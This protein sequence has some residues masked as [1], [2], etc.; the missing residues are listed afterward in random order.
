MAVYYN[1]EKARHGGLTGTIISVPVQIASNDPSSSIQKAQF[2]AGYLRCD[3][4]IY[5][6]DDYP[7]LAAVLG[8]GDN[9]K[10]KKD[11][12][13][14]NATQFQLPDLRSKHIRAT[15]S[16]NIGFY[17]DLVVQTQDGDDVVK[18]GVGLEVLQNIESPYELTYNGSFYIP[19]Q[20]QA[21]KGEPAFSIDSGSYTFEREV[22]ET[23]FQPHMHRSTTSRARQVDKNGNYF[24]NSQLNSIK[25]KLSLTVCEWWKNT[26]QDLC[27]WQLT[28]AAAV[29]A[30]GKT[31]NST[32]YYEQYGLCWNACS[33][34]TTAGY[35]L[36]PST[37]ACPGLNNSKNMCIVLDVDDDCNTLK[38][39]ICE[40]TTFG[41]ITYDPT[42]TQSCVCTLQILGECPGALNGG[43]L[44]LPQNTSQLINYDDPNMPVSS[45]DDSY[46][47]GYAAV[48]NYTMLTGFKGDDAIHKHTLNFSADEPHTYVMKTR[49]GTAS[50]SAGLVSKIT[51]QKNNEPKADKYIQPYIVTEYLIKI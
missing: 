19:P 6:A 2:P 23:G 18:S 27:Y 33:G 14:L 32:S 17:N 51:I 34:F 48:S 35:C 5:T 40:G 49:A 1:R 43:D 41:N 30:P 21:L 38:G 8:V 36:W 44:A 11:N 37:T 9:C 4:S 28:T 3:G 15:T 13:P 7:L 46:S 31:E 26:R 16:S 47:T 10:F 29:D 45:L 25:T 24:S 39:N 50:A 42:F 22:P 12:Q 20:S